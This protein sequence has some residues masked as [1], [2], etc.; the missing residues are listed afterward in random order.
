MKECAGELLEL[1]SERLADAV[2]LI[3][4]GADRQRLSEILPA[5]IPNGKSKGK[6]A[7]QGLQLH[8]EVVIPRAQM[9]AG[10]GARGYLIQERRQRIR[11][12]PS[13]GW[14]VF[15]ITDRNDL[16]ETLAS[17]VNSFHKK[18]GRGVKRSPPF[19]GDV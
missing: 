13:R 3:K 2:S 6:G 10:D 11:D 12:S 5:G 19:K 15:L 14:L 9:L 7:S 1:T 17:E 18:A 4:S 16:E 8:C